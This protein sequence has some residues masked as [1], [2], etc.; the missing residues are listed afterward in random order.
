ME[1]FLVSHSWEGKHIFKVALWNFLS[2]FVVFWSLQIDVH[3][4]LSLLFWLMT[5]ELF[6]FS[7]VDPTDP[8]IVYDWFEVGVLDYNPEDKCYLVQKVNSHGR[9]VDGSGKPVINGGIQPDGEMIIK[10]IES[11]QSA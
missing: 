10:L 2:M 3:E 11:R 7:S 5:V 8:K 9:V 6:N 4:L 1:Y